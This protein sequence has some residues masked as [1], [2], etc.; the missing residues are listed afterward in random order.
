MDKHG[1]QPVGLRAFVRHRRN[2]P[3]STSSGAERNAD[4]E[5]QR[6]RRDRMIVDRAP[7]IELVLELHERV[8]DAL[9]RQCDIVLDF[10]GRLGRAGD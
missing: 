3:V 9:L 8:A 10:D 7:G 5:G 4:G 1:Q 6:D 2:R